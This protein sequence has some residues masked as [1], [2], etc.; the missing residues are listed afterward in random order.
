MVY[1][2]SRFYLKTLPEKGHNPT[3]RATSF[4]HQ[5]LYII[6]HYTEVCKGSCHQKWSY[7]LFAARSSLRNT[8]HLRDVRIIC[9]H[10]RCLVTVIRR[11]KP[12]Y[13]RFVMLLQQNLSKAEPRINEYLSLSENFSAS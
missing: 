12:T 13:F 6:S 7:Y 3:L 8:Q 2:V 10:I 9:R 1:T 4:L 11:K 5:T